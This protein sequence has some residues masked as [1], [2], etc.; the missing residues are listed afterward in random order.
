M[1]GLVFH[2]DA[3]RVAND[4]P[5]PLREPHEALLKIRRAGVCNTDLELVK[6]YMG[7]SGILGH[8]FV[9]EVIEGPAE[10]LGKRV[11][12]EINVACGECDMC[13]KDIPSQCRHRSTVGIDRHPGAFAEQ[14]ALTT[15][16]LHAVPDAI[17]DDQAV[18]VEPLAAAL[19][20]LE[21]VHVSPRD[22]VIV[23]GAGKLGMLCAQ[24]LKL[25]GADLS[26][27]V[28]RD[29]QAEL[30]TRWGIPAVT[31]ASL[32]DHHA[33]IVVDATGT[34]AGFADALDLVAP[35]GTVVLKSTYHDVPHADLTRVVV[36]EVRVIGSRCGPF[37]AAIRVLNAGLVDVDS[38][39]EARY[40]LHHAIDAIDHAAQR[41]VFKVLLDF[42]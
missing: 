19:Q 22:R 24:V 11:V 4:L 3:L 42:D 25:T 29:K 34:P 6:G 36:D 31:R 1:R 17:S 26:V 41:G 27:I 12:G 40:P 23:I 39:I 30:L 33:Q 15:A 16:N 9:A 35:R 13:H 28:R 10:W 18:F 14:L 38:L 37:D 21:A 8:E 5:Q 32:K 20:I 7:F 2:N